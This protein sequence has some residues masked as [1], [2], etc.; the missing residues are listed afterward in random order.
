MAFRVGRVGL[1]VVQQR[2]VEMFARMCAK[3]SHATKGYTSLPSGGRACYSVV[4][5]PYQDFLKASQPARSPVS[6]FLLSNS[7]AYTT[8]HV[9]D[10]MLLIA[11][12]QGI[13]VMGRLTARSQRV[14]GAGGG[15][16]CRTRP[17]T[18]M[19]SQRW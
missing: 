2:L 15:G 17:T 7:A 6:N 10:L 8:P 4:S 3:V 11:G 18:W 1:G 19:P 16:R 12:H 13:E 14:K 5:L 9:H